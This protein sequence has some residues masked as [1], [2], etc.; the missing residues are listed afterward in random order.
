MFHAYLLTRPTV[1][2]GLYTVLLVDADCCQ[3]MDS[4]YMCTYKELIQLMGKTAEYHFENAFVTA[5]NIP[6]A[7]S[8]LLCVNDSG[9]S[10]KIDFHDS[11]TLCLLFRIL[12]HYNARLL[13]NDTWVDCSKL[14]F[15]LSSDCISYTD[16]TRDTTVIWSTP[17]TTDMQPSIIHVRVPTEIELWLLTELG[18]ACT[19]S[20]HVL[21]INLSLLKIVPG[22]EHCVLRYHAVELAYIASQYQLHRA[23]VH[24]VECGSWFMHYLAG[25]DREMFT[26]YKPR[27][28]KLVSSLR[29]SFDIDFPNAITC[30]KS[31]IKDTDAFQTLVHVQSASEFYESLLPYTGCKEINK[32]YISFADGFMSQLS[33]QNILKDHEL[34]NLSSLQTVTSELAIQLFEYRQVLKVAPIDVEKSLVLSSGTLRIDREV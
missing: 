21:S 20:N 16:I 25:D 15:S 30:Q 7:T 12:V 27:L 13:I 11:I 8:K 14:S 31:L 32:N 5:N 33:D 19:I 17:C 10:K 1:S 29:L 28:N 4:L 23:F 26:H 24:G 18:C 2:E 22:V 3:H 6:I 34:L 9:P